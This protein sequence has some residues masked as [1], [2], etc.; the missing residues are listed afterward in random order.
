MPLKQVGV[1]ACNT[2]YQLRFDHDE[3]RQT[4]EI[5]PQNDWKKQ[6]QKWRA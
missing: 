5:L 2:E 3:A 6:Q 4:T 1:L